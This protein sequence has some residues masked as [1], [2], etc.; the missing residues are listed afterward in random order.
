MYESEFTELKNSELKNQEY[1]RVHLFSKKKRTQQY[2]I[3]PYSK[4]VKKNINDLGFAVECGTNE[5][6]MRSISGVGEKSLKKIT[7]EV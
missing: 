3:I 7:I 4:T 1:L 5:V 6:R 2:L